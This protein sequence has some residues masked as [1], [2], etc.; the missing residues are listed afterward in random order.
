MLPSLRPN[1]KPLIF[2]FYSHVNENSFSGLN[3]D[4]HDDDQDDD[5]DCNGDS[6]GHGR[7]RKGGV[8]LKVSGLAMKMRQCK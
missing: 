5:G 1:G 4:Y 6:G 8:P 2:K 3:N 7:R